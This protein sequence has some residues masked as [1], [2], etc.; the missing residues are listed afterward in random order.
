MD[1]NVNKCAP[2][3]VLLFCCQRR[4]CS[5]Y[6]MRA[7]PVLAKSRIHRLMVSISPNPNPGRLKNAKI[8]PACRKAS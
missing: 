2:R 4:P 5:C 8:H 3:Y 6:V 7:C 1:K